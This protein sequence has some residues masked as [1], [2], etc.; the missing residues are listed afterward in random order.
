M[1]VY[2]VK[3][4]ASS[5][6]QLVNGVDAIIVEAAGGPAAITAAQ[7]SSN[8]PNDTAWADATATVLTAGTIYFEGKLVSS[9]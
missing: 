5:A 3:L 4:P 2:L 7:A 1:A 9:I 8:A 6:N